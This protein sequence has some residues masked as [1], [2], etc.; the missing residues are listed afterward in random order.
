MEEYARNGQEGKTIFVG[1]D[2]HRFKWEVTV[3]TGDQDLFRCTVPVGLGG[4][5]T[6]IE[7]VNP[8][9]HRSRVTYRSW[10]ITSIFKSMALE[11]A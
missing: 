2:L 9:S 11:A 5:Q 3:R 4:P 7:S 1:E 6:L 10:E 8:F